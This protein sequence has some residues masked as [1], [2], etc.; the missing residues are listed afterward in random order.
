[1]ESANQIY[2]D[3]TFPLAGHFQIT[4]DGSFWAP[5]QIFDFVRA[6]E[7]AK[8]GI[9]KQFEDFATSK[10]KEVFDYLPTGK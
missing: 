9:N 7:D 2:I 5:A 3:K 10:I 4:L 6:F 1:L 8:I